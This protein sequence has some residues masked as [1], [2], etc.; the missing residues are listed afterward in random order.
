MNYEILGE[1]MQIFEAVELKESPYMV[2][3]E[4]FGGLSEDST[5]KGVLNSGKEVKVYLL[6]DHDTKRIWTYNGRR[7]P[8]KL[9]IYG[10]ILASMMRRQLKLFYRTFSLN[11]YAK[12]S[13]E[14]QDLANKEIGPG[15]AHGIT[16]ED[17]KEF[18]PED[19]PETEC[20]VH[21][22]LKA[23]L[24]LDYINSLPTVENFHRMF[25]IVAGH[26][27][28]DEEITD[29]F[30]RESKTVLKT[31]KLGRLNNGFTFFSDN[32][33]SLRLII[34]EKKVQG[35]EMYLDK[36]TKGPAVEVSIPILFE[37]KFNR[38]GDP[39]DIEKA[40]QIPVA[41][42]EEPKSPGQ[43]QSQK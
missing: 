3:P 18:N 39:K 19:I 17:F 38:S 5:V 12:D 30:L 32:A 42:T 21:S 22:D 2:A 27:Y 6:V 10:G 9:Q 25:M 11:A 37:E 13:Q 20:C 43:N 29:S 23:N 4:V 33:Y 26:F 24:A 35:I 7:A 31:T 15:R 14:F 40:F 36:S 1:A 16:A 28:T 34:K 8:F 41:P